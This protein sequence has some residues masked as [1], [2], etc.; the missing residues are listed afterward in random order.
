MK[1]TCPNGS[2]KNHQISESKTISGND[3]EFPGKP[4]TAIKCSCG[5]HDEIYSDLKFDVGPPMR[6]IP[7]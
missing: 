1:I 5:F 2:G 4:M 7:R 3:C 6:F